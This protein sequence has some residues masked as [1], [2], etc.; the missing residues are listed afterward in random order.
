[1]AEEATKMN[2]MAAL[3]ARSTEEFRAE[4]GD[5]GDPRRGELRF[6]L[7]FDFGFIVAYW[8]VFSAMSGLLAVQDFPAAIWL[9]VVA[10]EC[11]TLCALLDVVE[12]VQAMRVLDAASS[13]EAA[14]LIPRMRR[15]SLA[16]WLFAFTATGILSATFLSRSAWGELLIGALFA[17]A[18]GLGIACVA[19][20]VALRG[21]KAEQRVPAVVLRFAFA[22]MGLVILIGLPFAASFV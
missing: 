20:L 3:L 14:R 1:M 21:S 17:L 19:V 8:A 6:Q 4:V 2:V 7:H 15:Y 16:K 22:L 5:P 12:N 13:D 9:G 18:A 11:A 10:A